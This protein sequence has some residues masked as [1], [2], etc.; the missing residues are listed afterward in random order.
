MPEPAN[1][2]T[3]FIDP[4]FDAQQRQQIGRAIVAHIKERTRRGE[5]IGG[6]SFTGP[7]GNNRYSES[8]VS[9]AEFN[10]AGKSRSGNVNLTLTGDMLDSLE[11]IDV[12]LAG[13]IVIGFEDVG[14]DGG[15]NDKSVW[16]REKGYNFLGLSDE[17]LNN[18]VS[19]FD[20]PS[21]AQS[22]TTELSESFTR[23]LLRSLIGN[24]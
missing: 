14:A 19:Q 8:Y 23:S 22:V 11:V 21:G 20:S 9:S 18:I 4:A 1:T 3:A 10:A 7:D 2:Y 16:M 5:G 17:E 15:E 24:R 13:R 12:T 6:R